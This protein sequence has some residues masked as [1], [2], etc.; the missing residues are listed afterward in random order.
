MAEEITEI[1]SSF[2][3]FFK[4]EKNEKSN[5]TQNQDDDKKE[6]KEILELNE[7]FEFQRHEWDNKINK[8]SHDIKSLSGVLLLQNYIYSERQKIID[9][10][11]FFKSTYIKLNKKYRKEFAKRHDYYTWHSQ[12]RYPNEKVKTNKILVDLEE[13]YTKKE[14]LGSHLDFLLKTTQTID[15]LIYGIKY[16]LEIEQLNRGS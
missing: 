4:N 2:D 14:I 3:D 7:K 16:R 5:N 6:N 9:E 8:M 12:R 1:P 13:I 15:N 11:H 10:Y